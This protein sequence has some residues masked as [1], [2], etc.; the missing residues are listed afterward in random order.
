VNTRA[1]ETDKLL[2][3]QARFYQRGISVDEIIFFRD[4]EDTTKLPPVYAP[5]NQEVPKS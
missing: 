3:K 2:G 1:K 4:G 5:P